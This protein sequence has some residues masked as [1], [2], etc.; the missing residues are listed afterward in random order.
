MLGLAIEA[1]NKVL[2][3]N[4]PYNLL[5]LRLRFFYNEHILCLLPLIRYNQE[6]SNMQRVELGRLIQSIT[7]IDLEEIDTDYI[8]SLLKNI[9]HAVFNKDDFRTLRTSIRKS[10]CHIDLIWYGKNFFK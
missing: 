2:A 1:L 5:I 7:H 6:I 10:I 4:T 9:H 8:L 3:N